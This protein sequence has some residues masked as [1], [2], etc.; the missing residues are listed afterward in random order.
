MG[1]LPR[2]ARIG[3]YDLQDQLLEVKVMCAIL[4]TILVLLVLC[5]GAIPA[6]SAVELSPSCAFIM[7]EWTDPNWHVILRYCQIIDSEDAHPNSQPDTAGAQLVGRALPHLGDD[8]VAVSI[9]DS[10][11]RQAPLEIQPP[12][13]QPPSSPTLLQRSP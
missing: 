3:I 7:R 11:R 10:G 8:S 13:P 2:L 5:S 12:T 4:R 6:W 1:A 9:D